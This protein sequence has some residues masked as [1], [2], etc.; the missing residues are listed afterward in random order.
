MPGKITRVSR[1]IVL[2]LLGAAVL[3]R[4]DHCVANSDI[5][6]D[7]ISRTPSSGAA[8][9]GD[10]CRRTDECRGYSHSGQ[11]CTLKNGTVGFYEA[12][13][14][15][16]N[17]LQ[18]TPNND[19]PGHDL[20]SFNVTGGDVECAQRCRSTDTCT[21]FAY[22]RGNCWLKTGD[23]QLARETVRHPGICSG[24]IQCTPNTDSVS[25]VITK[26]EVPRGSADCADRCRNTMG[27][28]GFVYVG[29]TCWLKSDKLAMVRAPGLCAGALQC[30]SLVYSEG[31]NI[32]SFDAP[33]GDSQCAD[34]CRS[35]S[36][37]TGFTYWNGHCWLKSGKFVTSIDDGRT[38]SGICT[39]WLQ[40]K[41]AV[42]TGGSFIAE[43][44]TPYG[45]N[46]C[47]DRCRSTLNCT[48]FTYWAG[49]CWLK[50]GDFP[51][52]ADNQHL[53]LCTGWLQ[54]K[55]ATTS[56]GQNIAILHTP[57]GDNECADRCRVT[58]GCT[59]FAYVRETCYLKTGDFPSYPDP[60]K[61]PVCTA[62]LQ[63]KPAITS[64][65][66]NIAILH[67]PRGDNQCADRCR[68]TTGCT[69]FAYVRETC[70]LKSGKFPSYPDPAN[71][72][73]CT[74]GL[75]CSQATISAG[76]DLAQI[77]VL[78]GD[79]KCADLCMAREA[80]TGFTFLD[81]RCWLKTGGFPVFQDDGSHPGVCTRILGC[82]PNTAIQ[83]P[84]FSTTAV[85]GGERECSDLC[86]ADAKCS[87]FM[88]SGGV[89]SLKT[90]RAVLEKSTNGSC[91]AVVRVKRVAAL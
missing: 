33:M 64:D 77:D 1:A 71:N 85:V 76:Q 21:G 24:A 79:S 80:C 46:E 3:A 57:G 52:F 69:G 90:G 75:Q 89:C 44:L 35:T 19:I 5:T 72:P 66:Q 20:I 49:R 41:A 7:H 9:C 40:C 34:H 4:A 55:A 68:N 27:C 22:W 56:D 54:C 15:C 58:V 47:A 36:G 86:L 62:G 87:G 11:T 74:A 31:P 42:S 25:T 12:Q 61:N 8:E 17:V 48:G 16:S 50:T 30:N 70:Y 45:D 60:A 6:G 67:T 83:A 59:G 13:G 53:G 88:L 51:S 82:K 2:A 78:Q 28:R 26:F 73:V 63:C 23:I 91:S 18:C 10:L 14:V 37:C 65:G 29:T 43:V 84:F 39:G 81:G 38:H 32:G